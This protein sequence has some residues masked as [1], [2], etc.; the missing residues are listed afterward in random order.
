MNERGVFTLVALCLLLVISLAIRTIQ[1]TEKNYSYGATNFQI[2]LEL[3][4]AADSGL[5]EAAKKIQSGEIIIS[6]PSEAEYM[7]NRKHWQ[8]KISV[9]Q[10]TDSEL[11]KNISVE[12]YGERGNIS[13]YKRNYNAEDDYIGTYAQYRDIPYQK[14]FL[15]ESGEVTKQ[16]WGGVIILISVA[17]GET[18][19]GTKKFRRSLAYIFFNDTDVNDQEK[20]IIHFMN[21]AER[22][23]LKTN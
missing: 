5:I 21:D 1:D 10:P 7:Q 23:G 8:R 9:S 6:A 13:M 12:V 15:T 3:Q 20:F 19:S 14:T 2:E 16:E 17:S 11:L 18:N 4:S 22:G